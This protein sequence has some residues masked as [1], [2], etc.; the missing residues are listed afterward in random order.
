M[1]DL[2]APAAR[3]VLAE[4]PGD[5][6]LTAAAACQ[7][8]KTRA[9]PAQGGDRPL[10]SLSLD[11]RAEAAYLGRWRRGCWKGKD[12]DGSGVADLHRPDADAGVPGRQGQRPEVASVHLC[13]LPKHLAIHGRWPES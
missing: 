8:G 5:D 13:L 9:G 2:P 4:D 10:S 1:A 6:R 3:W 7:Q 12:D 11:R